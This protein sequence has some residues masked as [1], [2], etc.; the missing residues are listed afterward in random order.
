[1]QLFERAFAQA[2]KTRPSCPSFMTS[3]L[4]VATGVMSHFESLDEGY[5]TLPEVLQMQGF[6]T[7]SFIQNG[8]AGVP[9]GLAEVS[10]PIE[11]Q[12]APERLSPGELVSVLATYDDDPTTTVLIAD[13]VVVLSYRTDA[14]EFA[15]EGV[16][17]LGIE[18]GRVA[19]RIV[20][21]VDD[22]QLH[23][24]GITSAPEVDLPDEVT[25]AST[26]EAA[27]E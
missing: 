17:R 2:T 22:G 8:N 15:R 23:V 27:A 7:G 12:R 11:P 6:A 26:R 16:L 18:D 3:L 24:I 9:A 4:P 13:R 25:L 5:V 1:M 19:A 14:S 10:I 21:A 20:N